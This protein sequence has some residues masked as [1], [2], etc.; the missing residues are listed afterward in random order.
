M[1][2]DKNGKTLGKVD[3]SSIGG[4]LGLAT[5]LISNGVS[6]FADSYDTE[7]RSPLFAEEILKVMD[8]DR[9]DIVDNI[10][11][12]FLNAGKDFDE[13]YSGVKPNRKVQ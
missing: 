6:V 10:R 13:L 7:G 12:K 11:M 5:G 3:V 8:H 2:W 9:P 1:F 4:N